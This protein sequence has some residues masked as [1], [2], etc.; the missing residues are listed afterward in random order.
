MDIE[1]KKS[2]SGGGALRMPA[3]GA[4]A[5]NWWLFALRGVLAIAF[6]ILALVHPL[7]ALTAFVL[8]FGIWAF[9]DGVDALVVGLSG[10][11]SWKLALGGAIGIAVG[12]FTFFK[13]G[14]AALGLY[15]AVAAW[16]VFR[17]VLEIA[18][19]IEL[20]K[21]IRGEVW[22]VFAGVA[23][24]LFGVLMIALPAAGVLA[25]AWLMGIYAL[26]FGGLMLALAVRLRKLH[27]GTEREER[28]LRTP[29][30]QPA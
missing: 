25:L 28:P 30:I 10:W 5:S 15:A 18:V 3:V 19:A 2:T 26:L 22:L 11:R 12:V 16:S 1:D 7:A 6:G 8:V 14:I 24:I 9:I 20:R 27:R 17:G 23:S 21:V 13:P 29:T 4:L